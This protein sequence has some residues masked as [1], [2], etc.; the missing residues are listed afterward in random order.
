[1]TSAL[2]GAWKSPMPTPQSASRAA[3]DA[4]VPS[5]PAK[6]S[7]TS[8]TAT[9]SIPAA[10]SAR[11]PKRSAIQPEKGDETESATGTAASTSP[12]VPGASARTLA[13]KNGVRN[14]CENIAA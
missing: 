10:G 12:S 3:T 4:T 5:A 1:M 11:A 7:A 8:P 6:E 9:S 2:F 14:V 13:R